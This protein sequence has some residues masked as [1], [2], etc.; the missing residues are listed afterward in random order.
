MSTPFNFRATL[1]DGSQIVLWSDFGWCQLDS[2][3]GGEHQPVTFNSQVTLYDCH[4]DC[5][6][7]LE[8]VCSHLSARPCSSVELDGST[9]VSL[10]NI[11]FQVPTK[12]ASYSITSIVY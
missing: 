3:S 4:L 5:P 2:G 6:V 9:L 11:D 8:N 10:E 1:S 7:M 12:L